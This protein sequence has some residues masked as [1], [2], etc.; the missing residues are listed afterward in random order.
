MQCTA[1]H[2]LFCCYS[3]LGSVLLKTFANTQSAERTIKQISSRN[4]I[5][6]GF[7]PYILLLSHISLPWQFPIVFSVASPVAKGPSTLWLILAVQ[8]SGSLCLAAAKQNL[9]CLKSA[10]CFWRKYPFGSPSSILLLIFRVYIR[11]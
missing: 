5:P 10:S 1:L 7:V 3:G 2:C 6:S 11:T 8:V 9:Q 4:S